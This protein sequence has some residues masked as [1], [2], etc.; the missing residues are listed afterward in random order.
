MRGSSL[1]ISLPTQFV[2]PVSSRASLSALRTS[3]SGRILAFL[4]AGETGEAG[5]AGE[6]ETERA[7]D[8]AA[9]LWVQVIS[10]LNGVIMLC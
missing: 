6:A 2:S 3:R 10:H 1:P 9:I 8:S 7:C 4:C 5:E